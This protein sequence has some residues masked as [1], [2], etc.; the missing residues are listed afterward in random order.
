MIQKI[1]IGATITL[2][3][4]VVILIQR[5]HILSLKN[6]NYEA[7]NKQLQISIQKQNKKIKDNELNAEIYKNKLEA[8]L[9][10]KSKTI[11]KTDDNCRGVL[12]FLEKSFNE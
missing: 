12:E 10:N 11:I 7:N 1:L 3:V 6:A 9:K 2:F 5:V 4:I 8:T